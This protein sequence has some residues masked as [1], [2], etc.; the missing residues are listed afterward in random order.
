MHPAAEPGGGLGLGEV[1]K[2]GDGAI[3][4][5]PGGI[6]TTF[7]VEDQVAVNLNSDHTRVAYTVK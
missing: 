7:L 2:A 3:V 4:V 5:P 6:G 1:N